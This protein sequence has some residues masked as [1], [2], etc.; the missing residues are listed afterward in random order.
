MPEALPELTPPVRRWKLRN[1]GD[2]TVPSFATFFGE[3][4]VAFPTL[5]F[6]SFLKADGSFGSRNFRVTTAAELVEDLDDTFRDTQVKL[7][8][9]ANVVIERVVPEPEPDADSEPPIPIPPAP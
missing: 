2:G 9:L 1:V 4:P 8:W 5:I 7:L 6:G 3:Q